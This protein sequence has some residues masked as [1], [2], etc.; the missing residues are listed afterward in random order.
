MRLFQ[1]KPKSDSP[2]NPQRTPRQELESIVPVTHPDIR[3]VRRTVRGV[4]LERSRRPGA[5]DIEIDTLG[6]SVLKSLDGQKNLE[7]LRAE[8]AEAHQLSP[9]ESRALML[10]FLRDLRQRGL[11]QLE[12]SS[13]R[14]S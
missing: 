10:S 4:V 8:F 2:T 13:S 9:L 11:I 3:E 6:H 5:R 7:T 12:P 1:L 14:T